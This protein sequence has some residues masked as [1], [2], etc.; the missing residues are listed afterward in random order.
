MRFVFEV[1]D[2][3]CQI[4]KAFRPEEETVFRS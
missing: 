3:R 4:E 1:L 2:F